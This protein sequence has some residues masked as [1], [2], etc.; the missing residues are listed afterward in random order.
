LG[1]EE[2]TADSE[3]AKGKRGPHSVDVL[4]ISCR[5]ATKT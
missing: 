1:W 4:G 3:K 2:D 5:H